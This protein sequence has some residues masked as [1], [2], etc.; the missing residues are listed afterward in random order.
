MPARG[1]TSERALGPRDDDLIRALTE[2]FR[3]VSVPLVAALWVPPRPTCGGGSASSWP[4][5]CST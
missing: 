1:P 5:T 4:P 3:L 2:R